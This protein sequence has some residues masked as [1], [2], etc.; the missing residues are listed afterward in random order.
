MWK[1]LRSISIVVL[2]VL[3]ALLVSSCFFSASAATPTDNELP[4]VILSYSEYNQLKET[5]SQLQQKS[6]MQKQ[7]IETLEK[8]LQKVDSS[9]ATSDTTLTEALSQLNEAKQQIAT[10]EQ[11]LQKLN[12]LLVTQSSQ[13][14]KANSSLQA[15]NE[16]LTELTNELKK[17]QLKERQNRVW[18]IIATATAVYLAVR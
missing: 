2:F 13:L 8:L 4:N 15:A 18:A 12:S 10:Q 7:Q 14:A 6:Q 3:L 17:Q 1:R 16:S 11:Q 5:F 9:T